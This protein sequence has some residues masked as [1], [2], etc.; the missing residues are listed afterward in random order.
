MEWTVWN[1]IPWDEAWLYWLISGPIPIDQGI[2]AITD[3]LTD[4]IG[5]NN[6]VRK[7]LYSLAH[8]TKEDGSSLSVVGKKVVSGVMKRY[9]HDDQILKLSLQIFRNIVP[10]G[11]NV[12]DCGSFNVN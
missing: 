9:L 3:Y 11:K 12:Y 10:M 8:L 2:D 7:A 6:S 5:H 1:I 4:F